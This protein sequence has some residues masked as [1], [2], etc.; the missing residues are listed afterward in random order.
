MGAVCGRAFS[1]DDIRLK[2]KFSEEATTE[3]LR[4]E[5]LIRE[6]IAGLGSHPWAGEYFYGDGLGENVTLLIAPKN[7]YVFKTRGCGGLYDRN[8][9]GVKIGGEQLDLSFQ[10]PNQKT[11]IEGIAESLR[12]VQW[13]DRVYLLG[14]KDM[15]G[16][17]N[18]IN[19]GEEPRDMMLG[20]FFLRRG[21]DGKV[22]GAKL[23]L[24]H[25]YRKYLLTKP[26]EAQ[27]VKVLKSKVDSSHGE[28]KL[29][30]VD[31]LLQTE[32]ENMLLPGMELYFEDSD[33]F[34]GR[35]TVTIVKEQAVEAVYE[36]IERDVI[37]PEAG[38]K[39]STKPSWRK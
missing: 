12:P 2:S 29:I 28:F 5:Q 3:Y 7:G 14:P 23:E 37:L 19:S 39:L 6:E 22:A 13:G 16:F 15:I 21:D 1:A 26:V 25:D 36:R 10:F 18:A 9:G 24:P 38:Q 11:R 20:N 35:V 8:F 17:C 31:L 4:R 32:H 30:V 34:F 33:R 27:L